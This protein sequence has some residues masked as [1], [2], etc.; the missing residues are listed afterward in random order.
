MAW[1][2][3]PLVTFHGTDDA[4]AA[5]IVSSGVR[6]ALGKELTDF[7]RGFYTTTNLHQAK[8]WANTRCRILA[9]RGLKPNATVVEL[10]LDRLALASLESLVFVLEN[11]SADFWDLIQDCRTTRTPAQTHRPPA[12]ATYY[13][14]VYGPVTLWPQTLVIKDCDQISFHTT[15]AESLVNHR[16]PSIAASGSPLFV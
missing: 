13:D 14:V 15:R 4:S 2:N 9:R 5:A 16:K 10:Q 11:S 6:I 8:N 7:G 3:A 1:A 12:T